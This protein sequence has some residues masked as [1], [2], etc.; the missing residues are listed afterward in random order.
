MYRRKINEKKSFHSDTL[1]TNFLSPQRKM[2]V[3]LTPTASITRISP[4]AEQR[5]KRTADYEQVDCIR[6]KIQKLR[7]HKTKIKQQ[8][9]KK[10]LVLR[11]LEELGLPDDAYA[12]LQK[13]RMKINIQH[14]AVDGGY[15]YHIK[16]RIGKWE[17]EG[18]SL[19]ELIISK[20]GKPL[21][22]DFDSVYKCKEEFFRGFFSLENIP[23]STQ[24]QII[25]FMD[26]WRKPNRQEIWFQ[27]Q[28]SL[29][30]MDILVFAEFMN[31]LRIETDQ[32]LQ[33]PCDSPWTWSSRVGEMY[34]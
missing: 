29:F 26:D 32:E 5:L 9:A 6:K 3:F 14:N 11:V 10:W 28:T 19:D 21:S 33:H 16:C 2:Q 22:C 23:T 17:I 12:C 4:I 34:I 24:D 18:W 7:V 31:H 27:L 25:A 13:L 20:N 1:Q 15:E 30:E 8:L